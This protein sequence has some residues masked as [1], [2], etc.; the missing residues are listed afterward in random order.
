MDSSLL[1]RASRGTSHKYPLSEEMRLNTNNHCVPLLYHCR[2]LQTAHT[3]R[4]RHVNGQRTWMNLNL[5]SPAQTA[6][7]PNERN[8][9]RFQSRRGA[10]ARYSVALSTA[11]R[12]PREP[13]ALGHRGEGGRR[14]E[15]KGGGGGAEAQGGI[16]GGEYKVVRGAGAER[17][18]GGEVHGAF[19]PWGGGDKATCP[20][21]EMDV[22][23]MYGTME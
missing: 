4:S 8:G 19:S 12:E 18:R 6:V 14:T 13:Q 9:A 7:Q 17:G 3:S 21:D 2:L 22:N 11:E 16:S 20:R 15:R 5:P 23:G 10:T 1:A